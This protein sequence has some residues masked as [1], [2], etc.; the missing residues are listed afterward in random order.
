MK[1]KCTVIIG[2]MAMICFFVAGATVCA[3]QPEGKVGQKEWSRIIESKVA[4]QAGD[5][6]IINYEDGYV[7]A[8]G[9]GAVDTAKVK[10]TNARPM[11]LRAAT[12]DGYRNL[13]EATKGIQVDSQTTIRD[14]VTESDVINTAVSG[15]VKGAKVISKDYLSDGT[16]EVTIR[17]SL[18]GK[19]AQTIIPKAIQEEQKRE[20]PPPAPVKPEPPPVTPAPAPA[21]APVYTGM[22]VD[23]RGLGARPA[24][25]PK[26]LDE[27]GAEVYGSLIVDKTYAVSQ[28]I[29]GYARD[30]TAAQGNQRVTNNPLTVKGV[31]AEGAGKADIKISNDD[32]RQ[33]RSAAENL[34]FMK[35][36]RVM[37]VLD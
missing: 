22:V 4:E 3:A 37:I 9:I 8:V 2:M 14:F 32:A 27:A 12:V 21:A 10:G 29:S 34:S 31:S 35:Q 7:E 23:A 19:F 25:S 5:R 13:L 33:L 36:C 11:C 30:L 6:A 17:M 1:S 16:C 18:S 28:G 15:L 20:T 26:I 24:M